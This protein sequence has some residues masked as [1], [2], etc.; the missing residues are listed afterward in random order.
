RANIDKA[1]KVLAYNPQ[2]TLRAG[3]KAQIAWCKSML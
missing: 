2:T 1:A 3:L